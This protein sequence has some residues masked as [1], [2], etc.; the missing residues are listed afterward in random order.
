ME[1]VTFVFSIQVSAV[2][3]CRMCLEPKWLFLGNCR[4]KECK[5]TCIHPLYKGFSRHYICST[6]MLHFHVLHLSISI[7]PHSSW[8][9]CKYEDCE[10]YWLDTTSLICRY[11]FLLPDREIGRCHVIL[12]NPLSTMFEYIFIFHPLNILFN[13]LSARH[14]PAAKAQQAVSNSC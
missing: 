5:N 9:I 4:S 7:S 6:C 13:R 11:L 2:Y 14:L 1:V 8:D 3:R 10:W 12:L